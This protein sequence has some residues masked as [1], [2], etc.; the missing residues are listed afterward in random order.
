M[1]KTDRE[2]VDDCNALARLFYKMQGY[3]VPNDYKMY[4]AH[5]PHEV[6][7][8][9]MAVAAYEHIQGTSIEDCQSNLE[10]E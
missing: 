6:G 8:W 7:C 1:D 5:H 3:Q 2:L 4:D 10:Q 9:S